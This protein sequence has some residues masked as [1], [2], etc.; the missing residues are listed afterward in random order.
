[1]SLGKLLVEA[2]NAA[3]VRSST[4]F[5]SIERMAIRAGFNLDFFESRTSFEGVAA[6][7][8]SNGALVVLGMDV[9]LHF[10]YSFRLVK[11]ITKR[12][13]RVMLH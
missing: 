9:F 5:A 12:D 4:L 1:M 10:L 6:A 11:F 3:I 7:N 2:V 8:A 13:T